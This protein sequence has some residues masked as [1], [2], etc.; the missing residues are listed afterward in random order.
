MWV[1]YHVTESE[2][3]TAG[4]VVTMTI[5][6][7]VFIIAGVYVDRLD[8]RC[9]MVTADGLRGVLTLLF[10]P[11]ILTQQVW[12]LYVIAFCTSTLSVFF[13][14]ARSSVMKSILPVESLLLANT[15]M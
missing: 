14:P 1:I 5:P 10:I 11:A 9:L 2:A 4:V 7:L 12:L 8:R 3:A 15:M 6:R 13:L